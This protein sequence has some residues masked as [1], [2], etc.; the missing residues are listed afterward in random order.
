MQ[1]CI[2]RIIFIEITKDYKCYRV[3]FLVSLQII[4]VTAH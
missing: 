1:V 4:H 2:P 3:T